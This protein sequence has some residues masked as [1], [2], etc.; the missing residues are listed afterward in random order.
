MQELA[1]RANVV[2]HTTAFDAY[3]MAWQP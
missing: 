3:S 1:D 2:A